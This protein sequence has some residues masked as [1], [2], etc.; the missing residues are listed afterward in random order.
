MEYTYPR[1][2]LNKIHAVIEHLG[3]VS[4]FAPAAECL[5]SSRRYLAGT[6]FATFQIEGMALSMRTVTE[7]VRGR[8][9]P[10]PENW[11]QEAADLAAIYKK[12]RSIDP[13]EE[14]AL[15]AARGKIGWGHDAK[16][17]K[18][19]DEEQWIFRGRRM[20]GK[21]PEPEDIQPTVNK[22]FEYLDAS[23]DHVF[24]KSCIAHFTLETL[25]PFTDYN[26]ILG[27]L[28]QTLLLAGQYPV[29]ECLPYVHRIYKTRKSYFNSLSTSES[30]GHPAAFIDYMAGVIIAALLDYDENRKYS[31]SSSDRIVYFHKLGMKSFARKDYIRAVGPISTATATRDL[32]D[33]IY[34]GLF[35]KEG[36][37]N[38]TR[39]SCLEP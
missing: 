31:V 22:L 11:V 20:Y 25:Q 35:L 26:G 17:G 28:W 12:I 36:K 33:G 37:G 14:A 24:I 30:E 38:K 5:I 27:R 34:A 2:I 8:Y 7:I 32:Q 39:Y 29:F 23:G 16:P 6:L 19:R 1:E 3:R 15:K 13:M 10:W 21:A 4:A 9:V 18:F